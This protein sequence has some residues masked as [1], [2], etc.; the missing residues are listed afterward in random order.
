M[1]ATADQ[2]RLAAGGRSQAA[3]D[4]DSFETD[5]G[6]GL[7]AILVSAALVLGLAASPIAA[8]PEQT[9]QADAESQPDPAGQASLDLSRQIAEAVQVAAQLDSEAREAQA[10]VDAAEREANQA[11]SA[12]EAAS[13]R[14]SVLESPERRAERDA[15]RAE[16]EA[17]GAEAARK[18]AAFAARQQEARTANARAQDARLRLAA[19][20]GQ[21]AAVAAEED[22]AAAQERAEAAEERA[23]AIETE[24][25]ASQAERDEARREAEAL[26]VEAAEK[27][28][29]RA[30]RQEEAAAAEALAQEA[31]AQATEAQQLAEE[32]QERAE[33]LEEDTDRSRRQVHV[34]LAAGFLVL[35][36]VA[37]MAWRFMRRRRTKPGNAASAVPAES[38]GFGAEAPGGPLRHAGGQLLGTRKTQEDDLGF[39]AGE[40]LDPEGHHP[41]V[42]VADGMGGHAAGEVA[43]GLAVRGFMDAYGVEGRASDRLRKALDG[44]NRALGAAIDEN[45]ALQ[46]MGTTLVAA[47]LTSDGL[48]WISVGDSALLLYRDG[49]LKR[50]NEDHSMRPVIAA[51][52]EFD[53]EAADSMS[54]HQLRSALVGSDIAQIDVSSM[55]EL[56]MPG[57]VV[58][59]ATDGLD[60]LDDVAI[61]ARIE[62]H[63]GDGP[64]AIRDALLAGVADRRAPTQDNATIAVIEAP[65]Q[66]QGGGE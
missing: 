48:E 36:A 62:D 34:A 54:P 57:D 18:E 27:E 42:V 13:E 1:R 41:V 22:A 33:A 24:A 53:P 23:Q 58:L 3:V 50:L 39:I 65:D 64:V 19:L 21:A 31:R 11:R 25:N 20:E 5:C 4:T 6:G 28:A 30:A 35:L 43:S 51:L 46:S 29:A 40:T 56:L 10:A 47:A 14:L 12:A 37:L 45:P 60:T 52:R 63:R 15:A 32:Q 44:A 26:R 49:R 55:P 17:L 7:L 9:D 16:A 2:G 8:Q 61:A 59:A 38:A 66:E